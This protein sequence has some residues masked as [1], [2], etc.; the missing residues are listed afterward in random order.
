MNKLLHVLLF[1]L[2]SHT[3]RKRDMAV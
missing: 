1:P 2:Y 3:H